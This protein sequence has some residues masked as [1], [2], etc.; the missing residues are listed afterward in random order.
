MQENGKLRLSKHVLLEKESL[1]RK[2]E[3]LVRLC[4]SRCTFIQDEAITTLVIDG[5]LSYVCV[6]F[7]KVPEG[8]EHLL[9]GFFLTHTEYGHCCRWVGRRIK[10]HYT[11]SAGKGQISR[12]RDS[13]FKTGWVV[14]RVHHSEKVFVQ[15]CI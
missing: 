15:E 9:I 13:R 6:L 2:L 10:T 5:L 8:D 12:L 14:I 11:E 4:V 1:S 3:W 7:I